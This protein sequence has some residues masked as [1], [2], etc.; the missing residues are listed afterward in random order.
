[1][2]QD[3]V[4]SANEPT[5]KNKIINCGKLTKRDSKNQLK[6]NEKGRLKVAHKL[7]GWK[8]N[9]TWDIANVGRVK[10][11]EKENVGVVV[12]AQN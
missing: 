6:E 4:V 2:A 7:G 3:L 12:K 11:R 5:Q 9:G 1:M 10:F 8:L